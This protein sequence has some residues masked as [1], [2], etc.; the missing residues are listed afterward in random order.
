MGEGRAPTTKSNQACIQQVSSPN[1]NTNPDH[2]HDHDHDHD[3]DHDPDLISQLIDPSYP[4]CSSS[5]LPS[6]AHHLC[7]RA[8]V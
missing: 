3:P 5:S 7:P 4:P 2:D 1:R 6:L 8:P